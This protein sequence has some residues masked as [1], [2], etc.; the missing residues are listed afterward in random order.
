MIFCYIDESGTPEIPGNT[1]HFVL[2]GISIP[3]EKW[4]ICDIEVNKIKSNFGLEGCEIHTGWIL[5]SYVEQN[6][7]ANFQS[8]DAQTRR[9]EVEKLRI[10]ELLKLQKGQN[11]KSY[12]QTKKNYRKTL[13]YVHLTFEERKKFLEEIASLVSNWSF[14]RLFAYCVDK[15]HFDP[16]R[17][18]NTIDEEAFEQLVSRFEAYLQINS[19]KSK[20][21]KYGL[22]IHDNNE[23]I[24]KKHT[25]M[26]KSFH[27][28]G[29][30]WKKIEN[31][32]ETP[33]FV[34]SELTSLI[35]IADLCGYAL[36]RYF[37]NKEDLL[38][39]LIFKRADKKDGVNVG[40]RHFSDK[41]C[42]CVVCQSH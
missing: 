13:P 37:E 9:R 15:I 42:K 27:K 36:R 17:A 39:N 1:S 2:A 25:E 18:R 32:I 26:M 41:S 21:A 10:Q 16:N 33:L 24:S 11:S 31:I 34:N 14:A 28:K 20:S 5:R 7:I 8:L 4:K 40:V 22:M 29:T 23:T 19:K 38:F 35:Q 12:Q 3:V 6:K 30:F